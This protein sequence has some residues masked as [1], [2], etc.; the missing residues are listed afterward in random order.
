MYIRLIP[1]REQVDCYLGKCAVPLNLTGCFLGRDPRGWDDS[2]VE[3]EAFNRLCQPRVFWKS[4][5]MFGE[6]L[7]NPRIYLG[8]VRLYPKNIPPAS[9]RLDLS[10][11][12]IGFQIHVGRAKPQELWRV[13]PVYF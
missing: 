13:E 3:T 1:S 12:L 2:F 8:S 11:K 5:N 7:A 9:E 10:K 4:G 6:V